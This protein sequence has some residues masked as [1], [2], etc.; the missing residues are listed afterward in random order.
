[1]VEQDNNSGSQAAKPKPAAPISLPQF[2]PKPAYLWTVNEVQKWFKRHLGEF[3]KYSG[4]FAQVI[5]L[6][7]NAFPMIHGDYSFQH[8]ITGQ[9]L[10]RITDNTLL[11]MGIE[12]NKDREAILREIIKQ[13]LKTDIV[14]F[15]DLESKNA[16]YD[17]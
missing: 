8:E 17:L 10:L 2:R 12:D 9:A 1:M 4:L 14:D 15:R 13:R 7:L 3:E 16:H 11:R 5:N 6:R